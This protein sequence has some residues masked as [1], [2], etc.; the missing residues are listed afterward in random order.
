[1]PDPSIIDKK[2]ISD[3][4]DSS[5]TGNTGDGTVDTKTGDEASDDDGGMGA[6]WVI[7]ILILVFGSLGAVWHFF[8]DK[9]KEKFSGEGSGTFNTLS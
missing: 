8:G 1:M 4:T 6:G 9:I 7:L 2:P 5:K 3:S